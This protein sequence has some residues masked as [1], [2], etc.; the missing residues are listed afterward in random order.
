MHIYISDKA[1][2]NMY[3]KKVELTIKQQNIFGEDKIIHGPT[4]TAISENLFKFYPTYPIEGKLY[5]YSK[6]SRRLSNLFNGISNGG[7]RAGLPLESFIVLFWW[8]WL[9]F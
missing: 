2:K 7:W 5:C 1:Q 4:K 3:K 8:T 9:F 6:I